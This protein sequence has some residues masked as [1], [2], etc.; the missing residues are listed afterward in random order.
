MLID[1]HAHLDHYNFD[2]DRDMVIESAGKSNVKVILTAGINPETNRKTLEIAGKY[3]IVKP[4]LGIY[5]IQTL[6]KEIEA[7]DYP[8]KE[9]NFDVDAELAFI[10]KN[11]AKILAVGEV[12]L[13]YSM[14]EDQKIQK[15]LFE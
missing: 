7:G 9:N 1:I 14:G 4:C 10:K 2:N 12:G 6:Q 5:P 11:K 8:L 13:D 15:E 3:D